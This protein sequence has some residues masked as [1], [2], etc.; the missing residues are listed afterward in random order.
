MTELEAPVLEFTDAP[1]PAP[2]ELLILEEPSD[3]DTTTETAVKH[4]RRTAKSVTEQLGLMPDIKSGS[5]E[6]VEYEIQMPGGGN[7]TY[8]TSSPD[9]N[10]PVVDP[11]LLVK[12]KLMQLRMLRRLLKQAKRRLKLKEARETRQGKARKK[13]KLQ[14]ASRKKNR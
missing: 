4:A 7:E 3:S 12:R 2:T 1:A 5:D 10:V 13:N 14:K 9:G 6:S 11:M 8:N